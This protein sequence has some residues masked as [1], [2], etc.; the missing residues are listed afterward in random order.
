MHGMNTLDLHYSI[1]QV[2]VVYVSFTLFTL[3]TVT[4]AGLGKLRLAAIFGW[5]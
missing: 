1:Y 5:Q 4:V 2:R 3:A